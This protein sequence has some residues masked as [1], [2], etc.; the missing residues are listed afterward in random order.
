MNKIFLV[1]ELS[2]N[3]IIETIWLLVEID[4]KIIFI[5]GNISCLIIYSYD[6][7]SNGGSIKKHPHKNE[8]PTLFP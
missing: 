7:K 2:V 5:F 8:L 1:L 4:W 6:Q 3:E